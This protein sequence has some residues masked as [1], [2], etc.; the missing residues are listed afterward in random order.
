MIFTPPISALPS[1]RLP[2]GP[3]ID[4]LLPTGPT[5]PKTQLLQ[6]ALQLLQL[7][8]EE[9]FLLV[10]HPPI[11]T[12]LGRIPLD[13]RPMGERPQGLLKRQRLLDF[14]IDVASG[15]PVVAEFWATVEIHRCDDAHVSLAPFATAVGDLVFE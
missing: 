6:H 3:A 1:N 10:Q 9:V 14:R 7:P 4:A 2:L 8:N 15:K 13:I 12:H 5:P 11:G